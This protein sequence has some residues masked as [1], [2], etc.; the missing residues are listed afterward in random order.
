MTPEA[1]TDR[2]DVPTAAGGDGHHTGANV[3]PRCAGTGR[4][5]DATC[6]TCRGAAVVEEPIGD[7]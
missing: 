4:T 7:A 3:C 6:P 2:V 5:D 1:A